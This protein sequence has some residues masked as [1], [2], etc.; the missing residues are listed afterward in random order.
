MSLEDIV[1]MFVN[2]GVSVA[3]IVYF[4]FRDYKFLGNLE[5]TLA[6]LQKTIE[7][8]EAYHCKKDK[9]DMGEC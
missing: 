8:V 7:C 4:C 1:S 6:T 3:I 2:N 5:K 9:E